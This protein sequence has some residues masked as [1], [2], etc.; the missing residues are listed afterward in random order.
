MALDVAHGKMYWVDQSAAKVQRANL[1]G[2]GLEDLVTGIDG[3]SSPVG[4]A[5]STSLP[6]VP[7]STPTIGPTPTATPIPAVYLVTKTADT[8]DGACD[9]DCS[10]RE[11]ITAANQEPGPAIVM[12]PAGT[13]VLTLLGANE[14]GAATGDLDILDDLT[15]IGAGADSTRIDGNRTDRVFEIFGPA[16]VRLSGFTIQNGSAD[17][18]GG[19]IFNG[20]GTL[21]IENCALI[22]NSASGFAGGAIYNNGTLTLESSTL[23]GNSALVMD[24][25]IAGGGGAIDNEQGGKTTLQNCTLRGNSAADGGAIH[26]YGGTLTLVNCALGGNSS[27]A[28]GGGIDSQLGTL[29]VVN[30]TLS[31]NSA[32]YGGG[33]ISVSRAVTLVNCTLSG[34]S[35]SFLGGGGILY[36]GTEGTDAPATLANTIIASS[37]A[38]GNCVSESDFMLLKSNGHNLDDDGT[39]NLQNTGDLSNVSAHLAPLGDNGGPTQTIALLPNS[40]AINAGDEAVCASPPVNSLDQRGYIRPGTGYANCSIGA[41]EYNSS[42]PPSGT[43]TPTAMGTAAPTPS[44]T[45]SRT[46]TLTQSPTPSATPTSTPAATSTPTGSASPTATLTSTPISPSPSA[47]P[48]P[49]P[50]GASC[51]SG[52]QCASTFCVDT[53]CCDAAS[54]RAG[55]RCDIYGSVGTCDDPLP[56][57]K[58]CRQNSDCE[59]NNC[60]A[61]NPPRCG[62]PLPGC[63]GDCDNS[64]HVGVD[65]LLILVHIA[66]SN[67]AT[68]SCA[69]G[70]ADKNGK[71]DVAEILTAVNSAHSDCG[72]H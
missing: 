32:T 27:F 64:G 56:R 38:G 71:I 53:T 12:V 15:I 39:C 20:G 11:A 70:D 62:L 40:P 5:L 16:V 63:D 17:Y 30:C 37:L 7:T 14:D 19:G 8:A 44:P 51:T 33:G 59:S 10:L 2:S 66:L 54:C 42:G 34:N 50:T 4:I 25:V 23:S 68:A 28:Y 46:V 72:R 48:T 22:G 60:E 24:G 29:T 35:A 13:Y 9:N 1:D 57:G 65:D 47:T 58:A 61:G 43:V 36:F 45:P 67:G 69:T 21:T 18:A 41:Y 26:N 3:L 55:Q 49:Q 52:M 31:G 6:G